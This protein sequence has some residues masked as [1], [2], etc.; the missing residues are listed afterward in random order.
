MLALGLAP[1]AALAGLTLCNDADVRHAVAVGYKSGDRWVSEGWWNIDP[2]ACATAVGGD[3]T[4]RYYYF[5]AEAAGHDFLDE[6]YAFCTQSAA[7]TIEGDESCAAR[8]FEQK[9]FRQIDTGEARN[10]TYRFGPSVSPVSGVAPQ[11]DAGQWGEPYSTATAV[12]QDCGTGDG[13]PYCSFHDGGTKFFVYDDGRTPAAVMSALRGYLPGTPIAVS[14]DLEAIYDTSAAVVLRG[15]SSRAPTVWDS[16]LGMMQGGWYDP[17]DMKAQYTILGSEMET[18]Y[19]GSYLGREYLSQT[20]ICEGREGSFL[21][22]REEE[23]GEVYCFSLEELSELR[24]VLMYLPRGN[25]HYFNR[26]D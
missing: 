4:M 10:F 25:F 22:R 18:Y 2:G 13:G 5:R 19:D 12:F 16:T 20:D 24:F 15:V 26:L 3:L 1:G 11:G 23:T 8:G 14:G 7:F 9:M 17:E 6:D 21:M